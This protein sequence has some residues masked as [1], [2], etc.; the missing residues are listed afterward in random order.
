[1]NSTNYVLNVVFPEEFNA[2]SKARQ[3]VARFLL[4]EGYIA[5]DLKIPKTK[6][7]VIPVIKQAVKKFKRG[8]TLVFQ[9]P[10]SMGFIVDTAL[11]GV[12]KTKGVKIIALIHDIES[13]R[14]TYP[15]YRFDK[16]VAFEARFLNGFDYVITSNVKM[17]QVLVAAGL[18]V[19]C[20]ELEIFD[21]YRRAGKI[22]FKQF[23]S[24][25]KF[26]VNFAGNLK[27]SKFLK[28]IIVNHPKSLGELT[29]QFF[30]IKP[31]YQSIAQNVV[32]EGPYP[33]SV[34]PE[35]FL[36]GFGLVWDGDDLATCSGPLGNY[37][38]YNNPH[39]LSLY[40][41]AG[42]PVVVWS[43]SGMA[44]FVRTNGVGLCVDSLANLEETIKLLTNEEYLEMVNKARAI[45]VRLNDGYYTKS[46]VN[47]ALRVIGG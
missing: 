44:T 6:L 23:S 46:S 45:G 33:P 16:S 21:Y 7:S 38:R 3:D 2:T 5:F 15:K 8:D 10:T 27:K 47:R 4:R 32:L 14:D 37:L 12:L 28:E 42:L 41:S 1:M 43:Q 19:A 34:L 13:L 36:G 29:F 40:L 9:Y 22:G 17:S 35:Q 11:L 26:R 31:N 25:T 39:K 20:S 18:K 30:G 24:A